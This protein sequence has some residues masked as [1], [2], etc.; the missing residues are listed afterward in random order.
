[1]DLGGRQILVQPRVINSDAPGVNIA[2]GDPPFN[3]RIAKFQ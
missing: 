3:T 2:I 1:M